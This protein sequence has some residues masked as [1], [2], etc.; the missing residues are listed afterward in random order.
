[1]GLLLI[2]CKTLK[3]MEAVERALKAKDYALALSNLE[4]VKP[5]LDT[6]PEEKQKQYYPKYYYSKVLALYGDGSA[7]NTNY[8]TGK[9]FLE[10]QDYES[11]NK[12]IKYSEKVR[13][14]LDTVVNR[15]SRLGVS[16]YKEKNY[17]LASKSFEEV[18]L[19]FPKDTSYLENAAL[20]ALQSK[21]Y[22]RAINFY[23]K[24]LHLGYTGITKTF[25]AVDKQ[26]KVIYFPSKDAM[27]LQVKLKMVENP[28]VAVTES[29]AGEIVKNLALS[30]I[31]KGDKKTALK[32]IERAK[33]LFPNDYT[34]IIN[35]ATIHYQLGN[36][37]KFLEGL[38]KAI[39]LQ[40]NNPILRYNIGVI[41]MNKEMNDKAEENFR[42]AI[43]LKEDY[44]D[45]YINLGAVI[46]RKT[47][48]IVE[49]MNKNLSN[50]KKYDA[51]MV[52]KKA[53]EKEALPFF[54]KAHVLSPKDESI[55]KT[56]I[57]LYETLEMEKKRKQ[58]IE[59]KKTL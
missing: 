49:E 33:K 32:A 50:F 19:L 34:L 58:M 30:Y 5:I 25:K 6:L 20:T 9:A 14:I 47:D 46:L 45:A 26:G 21:Q 29:K 13:Y 42:L 22:D 35:E 59:K 57:N 16:S 11:E 1:M 27:D 44:T 24:C 10:L 54:E 56:L 39:E 51:L 2:G 43:K 31:A 36:Q 28:E 37:E 38:N 7:K 17:E 48:A 3:E 8:A 12:I 55:I 18:Y 15:I 53:I 40:P 52:K 4:K 23:K 41:A